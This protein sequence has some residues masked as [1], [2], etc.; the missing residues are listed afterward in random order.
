MHTDPQWTNKHLLPPPIDDKRRE[1]E[2]T[3]HLQALVDQVTKLRQA[4]LQACHCAEEFTLR[5]IHPLN[6]REKLAYERPWLADPTHEPAAAKILNSFIA[7][8]ELIFKSDNL[9]ILCSSIYR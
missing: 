7:D 6:H 5:R 4:S 8:I 1:P 2:M 3:P 9:T